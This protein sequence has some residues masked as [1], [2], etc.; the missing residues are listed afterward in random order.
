MS[1]T[2]NSS[3]SKEKSVIYLNMLSNVWSLQ[4]RSHAT[5][6]VKSRPCGKKEYHQ[7]ERLLIKTL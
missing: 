1:D 2:Q 3:D 7:T 5:C 6:I 4:V